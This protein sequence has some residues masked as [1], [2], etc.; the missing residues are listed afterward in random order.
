VQRV[1]IQRVRPVQRAAALERAR[2]AAGQDPEAVRPRQRVAAR[3]E[4]VR[5]RR[6]SRTASSCGV[7]A[8]TAI[9]FGGGPG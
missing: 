1:A 6:A 2:R 5:R 9:S 8:L 3:V 7:S 4:P